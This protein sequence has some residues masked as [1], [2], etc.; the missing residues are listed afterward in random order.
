MQSQDCS[1]GHRCI[2]RFGGEGGEELDGC[3]LC[4]M[5]AQHRGRTIWVHYPRG[6]RTNTNQKCE[7]TFTSK[8]NCAGS[9][10]L[11]GR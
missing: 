8:P 11:G 7:H 1:V 4:I 9:Y 6:M 10:A 5:Y 2:R 3:R